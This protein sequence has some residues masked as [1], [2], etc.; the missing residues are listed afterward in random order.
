MDSL[1]VQFDQTL[2]VMDKRLWERWLDFCS[3]Y[4]VFFNVLRKILVLSVRYNYRM[5]KIA[6]SVH[7][8]IYI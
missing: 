5:Y 8:A 4:Y 7:I 6:S 2:V 1:V 3:F